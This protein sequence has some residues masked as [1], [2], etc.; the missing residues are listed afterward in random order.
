MHPVG[1]ASSRLSCSGLCP[2]AARMSGR[3]TESTAAGALAVVEPTALGDG[4]L[5]L[6]PVDPVTSPRHKLATV[7]SAGGWGAWRY[8]EAK[9]RISRS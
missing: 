9:K 4:D 1:G 2:T 8:T 6:R 5:V 3:Q 7:G